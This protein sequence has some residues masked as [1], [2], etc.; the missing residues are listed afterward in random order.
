MVAR[1]QAGTLPA[2]GALRRP[3]GATRAAT[4]RKLDPLPRQFGWLRRVLPWIASFAAGR[5]HDLVQDP[6]MA[7]LVAAAPQAGRVLRPLCRMFGI[8]R[9]AYL[10]LRRGP[11]KPRAPCKTAGMPEASQPVNSNPAPR[12]P[13]PRRHGAGPGPPRPLPGGLYWNGIGFRWA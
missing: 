6:E 10:R 8:R 1:L 12:P 3:P 7:A 9:P 13:P 4:P 2:V 5:L 11:R